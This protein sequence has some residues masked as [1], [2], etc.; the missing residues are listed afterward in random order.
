VHGL[1]AEDGG[2]CAPSQCGKA[3]SKPG[4]TKETTMSQIKH[5]RLILISKD[6]QHL[7]GP[8]RPTAS[9]LDRYAVDSTAGMFHR[10]DDPLVI[11]NVDAYDD[12]IAALRCAVRLATGSLPDSEA[13][14][15]CAETCT[16]AL[17]R[18]GQR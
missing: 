18:A 13:R 15:H 17:D 10:N 16:A 14:R 3:G 2:A 4:P 8:F 9:E 7:Y 6:G 12:L 5:D 1:I 11:V